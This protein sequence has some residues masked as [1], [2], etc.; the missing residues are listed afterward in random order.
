MAKKTNRKPHIVEIDYTILEAVARYYEFPV[1][2]FFL[3]KK[4]WEKPRL[5]GTRLTNFVKVESK[6][7]RIR[8]ILNED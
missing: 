1:A 6:L 5:S 8:D 7:E 3:P 4:E 2:V